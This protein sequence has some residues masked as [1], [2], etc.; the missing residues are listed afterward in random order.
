MQTTIVAALEMYGL[1]AG[2]AMG[3]ALLILAL[4]SALQ[5]GKPRPRK[6]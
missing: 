2:I 1:A 3:V 5:R 6:S 4:S